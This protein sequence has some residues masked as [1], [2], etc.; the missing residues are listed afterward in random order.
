L[1]L[2]KTAKAFNFVLDTRQAQQMPRKGMIACGDRFAQR[3]F[4]PLNNPCSAQ[5][6]TRDKDTINR[7]RAAHRNSRL[8]DRGGVNTADNFIAMFKEDPTVVI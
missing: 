1:H 7:F 5:A 2:K 4:G 3:G 6:G 8:K